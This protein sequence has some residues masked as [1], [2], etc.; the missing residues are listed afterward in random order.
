MNI[1]SDGQVM[2]SFD[3]ANEELTANENIKYTNKKFSFDFNKLFSVPLTEEHMSIYNSMAILGE[4]LSIIKKMKDKSVHLIFADAPYNL[5]KDFGND[6]DRWGNVNDYIEWC[7]EW[8]D[9]CMRIL[10]DTGTMYFMTAT[11]HMPYLDVFVSEKYNVLCRIVW[12][13]D[14]SGVQSKKCMV[15]CMNLY[16]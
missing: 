3:E 4:S 11:Q 5:G 2:L 8:I 16:L 14:S 12:A 1:N 6:S 10:S 7:K 9:E 13:Y 15:L